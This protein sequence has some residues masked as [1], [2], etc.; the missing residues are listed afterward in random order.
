MYGIL[1]IFLIFN[2]FNILLLYYILKNIFFSS[3]E[4]YY[5]IS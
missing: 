2:T 5:S 1:I 3:N 4:S